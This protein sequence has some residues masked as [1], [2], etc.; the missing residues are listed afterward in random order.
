MCHDCSYSITVMYYFK[1]LNL[2]TEK[3]GEEYTSRDLFFIL[4]E[5]EK[6]NAHAIKKV[7]TKMYLRNKNIERRW[8]LQSDDYGKT[9]REYVYFYSD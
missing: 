6:V 3:K 5:E 8:V 2:L 4:N 7:L 9:W 1:I